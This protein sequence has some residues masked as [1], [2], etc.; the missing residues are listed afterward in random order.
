MKVF[1]SW[2][3]PLSHS[4][5]VAL[6]EWVP[7]VLPTVEIY[8]SSDLDKGVRW[9]EEIMKE[10]ESSDLGIICLTS[11]NLHKPWV[12]FESGAIAKRHG[13][14]HVFP[15]LVDLN[16]ADLP[17]PLNYFMAT[18]LT[19]QDLRKL[20][21]TINRLSAENSVNDTQL[22]ERF[23]QHWPTFNRRYTRAL[24]RLEIFRGRVGVIFAG[25][26]LLP[27]FDHNLFVHA[28]A[29]Y[30]VSK[31]SQLFSR[32]SVTDVE[33]QID[34]LVNEDER[35]DTEICIG[36]PGWNP[37]TKFYV[38]EY[39][40]AL[41]DSEGRP[42]REKESLMVKLKIPIL[43]SERYRTV[44]LIFGDKSRDTYSCVDYFHD[45]YDRLLENYFYRDNVVLRFNT[46][47]GA[48]VRYAVFSKDESDLHFGDN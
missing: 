4:I 37:R 33:Y 13:R 48:N 19:Q 39:C 18:V 38:D 14:A 9:Y 47:E 3:G 31:F 1:V 24:S 34:S 46:K 22:E 27:N 44:F 15:L 12:N 5:A 10:L 25:K 23:R 6:K 8:V 45:E 36:S 41:Y 17:S 7:R 16:L 20:I 35:F 2:S 11:S 42:V 26:A 43:G 30:Y 21:I 32:L 40:R 29:V 28:G